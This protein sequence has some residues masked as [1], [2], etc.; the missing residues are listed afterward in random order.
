[1]L[2]CAKAVKRSLQ[3]LAETTGS[4]GKLL[5]REVTEI[6]FTVSNIRAVL[7]HGAGHLEL[8]RLGT[9]VRRGHVGRSLP[10]P[11][12]L[13]FT[14]TPPPPAASSRPRS[15]PR[16]DRV[17]PHPPV[18]PS[19][20]SLLTASSSMESQMRPTVARRERRSSRR[21]GDGR[22][23]R[24]CRPSSSSKCR[25]DGGYVPRRPPPVQLLPLCLRPPARCSATYARRLPPVE[26][27]VGEVKE[28]RRRG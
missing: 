4:T 18:L 12:R 2:S 24:W 3:M 10:P 23:R 14:L 13:R 28:G 5:R 9:K 6:M 19:A 26:E 25:F 21:R 15:P 1:M 8:Q 20:D 27:R 17:P 7:Q 16:R 22:G 11:P